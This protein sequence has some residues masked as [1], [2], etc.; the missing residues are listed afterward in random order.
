MQM[1][2]YKYE[3]TLAELD[4]ILRNEARDQ[5]IYDLK[6]LVENQLKQIINLQKDSEMGKGG[7]L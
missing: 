5:V 3:T 6:K 2:L 1:S 4:V 7:Y